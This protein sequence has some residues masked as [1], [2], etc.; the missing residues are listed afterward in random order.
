MNRR[1]TAVAIGLLSLAAIVHLSVAWQDFPTLA[2]NGFLYDDAFY[3]FEIARNVAD[4]HGPTFDQ[5]H[6]T[7]GFQPLYVFILAVF[8]LVAGSSLTLPIYMSLS[9]MAALTVATAWLLYRIAR[10]YVADWVALTVMGVWVLSPLAIRQTANGM[11]TALAL[12]MFALC[13][14]YYLERI[15]SHPFPSR[16]SFITLGVLLSLAVLARLDQIFLAL[17]MALDYLVVARRRAA[18]EPG[19]RAANVAV[20]GVGAAFVAGIV[21]Y[22]PWLIYSVV[23]TGSPLQESGAA[24]RFLSVAYAPIYQNGSA[25]L[26]DRGP[27]AAFV[28]SHVVHSFSVLKQTPMVHVFFRAVSRVTDGS[29][30]AIVATLVANIVGL[31]ALGVFLIWSLRNDGRRGASELRFLLLFSCSLIAVYSLYVFGSFFFTRYYYPIFFIAMIY[32]ALLIDVGAARIRRARPAVRRGAALVGA[33]WLLAF[34]YMTANS[35]WRSI[36]TYRFYDIAMWARDVTAPDDKIGTFQSGA[37]GYL[38]NR[39]VINLDGKVNGAAAAA[40]RQGR[41]REYID[42]EGIDVVMDSYVVLDRFLG[43][44][45]PAEISSNTEFLDKIDGVPGWVGFRVSPRPGAAASVQTPAA[46][47]GSS[48]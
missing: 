48:H 39:Q 40:L 23:A 28:W 5:E 43:P 17:A 44:L 24:T 16:K 31:G 33:V 38:S 36:P 21:V 19:A 13:V 18:V 37:I 25:S 14:R 8:Y 10:R 1:H 35:A 27:D 20:S 3:A 47:P 2:K 32:A 46:A 41:L 30:V 7:T 45:K 9:L 12:F 42:A 34:G 6:L 29:S 22:L 26:L 15:R 4:G 11:E